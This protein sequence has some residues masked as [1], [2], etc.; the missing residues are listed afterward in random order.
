MKV[1]FLE[2]FRLI[3]VFQLLVFSFFLFV[4]R[5]RNLSSVFLGIHLTS[6]ALGIFGNFANWNP[7]LFENYS[8]LIL[9]GDPFIFLWGPTFYLYVKSFAF[10]DFKLKWQH[11]FHF[12]PF[13]AIFIY[14]L[15]SFYLYDAE[16][17]R[18]IVPFLFLNR[19]ALIFHY[20]MVLQI[21]IYCLLSLNVL[22]KYSQLLKDNFSS[23]AKINLS[24]LKYII[25]FFV[26]AFLVTNIVT[27]IIIN[28]ESYRN[29]LVPIN[30]MI[31]FIFF[32]T[33]FFKGWNQQELFTGI[34]EKVKYKSSSLTKIEAEKWTEKL[35][36]YV[37]TYK[38]YLNPG[39]TIDQLAEDINISPRILSQIINEQ[40]KQNFYDYISRLRIEEAKRILSL[41]G[42]KKT[43]LEIIY[44]T[45]YNSKSAFNQAFKKFTGL[46]PTEYRKR[47]E[48]RDKSEVN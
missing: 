39:L 6:Q 37:Q 4:K 22:K 8:H 34:D 30:F 10:P 16:T 33:I 46:T 31:Y 38:P 26:C 32:N 48:I 17:K 3:V 12:A 23:M 9:T 21:S 2:I 45:G 14:L 13:L 19:F 29:V 42:E 43:I 35:S 7:Y 36:Y 41:P 11:S 15:L 44:D 25:I 5:K 28:N 18:K 1:T 20:F 27:Y 40:F 47:C 24:W